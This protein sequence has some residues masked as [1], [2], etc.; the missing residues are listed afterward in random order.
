MPYS[1]SDVVR[2][3]VTPENALSAVLRTAPP[4]WLVDPDDL[5]RFANPAVPS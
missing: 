5:I 1:A 2:L 4:T 3:N